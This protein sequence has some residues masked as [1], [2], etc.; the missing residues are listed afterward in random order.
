MV[1]TVLHR[2]SNYLNKKIDMFRFKKG[3]WMGFLFFVFGT[4]IVDATSYGQADSKNPLKRFQRMYKSVRQ[5]GANLL[6]LESE[7]RIDILQ[8]IKDMLQSNFSLYKINAER[9]A[10][11]M[12]QKEENMSKYYSDQNNREDS[13]SICLLYHHVKKCTAA[14]ETA[15]KSGK[16]QD[17]PTTTVHEINQRIRDEKIKLAEDY[18]KSAEKLL[19]INKTIHSMSKSSPPH[20]NQDSRQLTKPKQ[21]RGSPDH[22]KLHSHILRYKNEIQAKKFKEKAIRLYEEACQ[23]TPLE[24]QQIALRQDHNAY[25]KMVKEELKARKSK[26]S[27]TD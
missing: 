14:L 10:Q 19:M 15:K 1:Y 7:N 11:R 21:K 25:I 24:K 8:T 23:M 20:S 27:P 13:D 2:L 3:Y 4:L 16:T 22:V 12:H 18:E 6:G 5:A 17:M 9:S 26:Q